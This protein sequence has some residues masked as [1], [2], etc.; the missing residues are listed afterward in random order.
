MLFQIDKEYQNDYSDRIPVRGERSYLIAWWISRP[1]NRI[2]SLELLPCT[3]CSD[4][5]GHLDPLENDNRISH[6][7]AGAFLLLIAYMAQ[8]SRVEIHLDQRLTPFLWTTNI[9]RIMNIQ[10]KL[11][12]LPIFCSWDCYSVPISGIRALPTQIIL[13]WGQ[14]SPTW[15][16]KATNFLGTD[17]DS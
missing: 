7:V 10:F 5:C 11:G 17:C 2:Y 15:Y 8:L 13:V 9:C 6:L 14:K 12:W 3:Y 4:K 16:R 1:F